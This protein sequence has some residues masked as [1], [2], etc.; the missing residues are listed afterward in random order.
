MLLWTLLRLLIRAKVWNVLCTLGATQQGLSPPRGRGRVV[1][2]FGIY[3]L[4]PVGLLRIPDACFA[5][6]FM[7][8]L[9]RTVS[10]YSA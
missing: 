7:C 9:P 3:A 5:T 10:Y 2:L 4:Q 1:C 6:Y 8:V